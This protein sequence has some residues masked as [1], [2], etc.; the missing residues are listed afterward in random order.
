MRDANDGNRQ[1][2]DGNFDG[3][4]DGN[5]QLLRAIMEDTVTM[6]TTGNPMP[7]TTTTSPPT[8]T[9]SSSSRRHTDA[10]R[11]MPHYTTILNTTSEEDHDL[12]WIPVSEYI[13]E[14]LK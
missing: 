4:S 11:L 3:N 2:M 12:K 14:T 6:A 1:L 10:L 8:T 7:T 9:T 5:Q 13:Q